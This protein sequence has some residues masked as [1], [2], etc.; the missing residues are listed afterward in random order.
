MWQEI[1]IIYVRYNSGGTEK[2]YGNS[3]SIVAFPAQ[4]RI[5]TFISF[6]ILIHLYFPFLH[7]QFF[8]M[9]FGPAG[10]SP[11]ESNV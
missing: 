8:S 2:N 5:G 10:P 9:R 11:G 7:L 3:V 1:G 4:T 6:S